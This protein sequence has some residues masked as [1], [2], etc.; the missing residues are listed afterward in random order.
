MYGYAV[1]KHVALQQDMIR[2]WQKEGDEVVA[3]AWILPEYGAN[4]CRFKVDETDYLY[5]A[6]Q[7]VLDFRHY[8]TPV[9]YPFPGVITDAKFT[10]DDQLYRFPPN[11]G[12]LYRHGFVMDEKF[13]YSEPIILDNGVMCRT[14]IEI[15]PHHPLYALLPISNRLDLDFTL[16]DRQL[17]ID[18]KVTNTDPEKRFPFGFGVHP[19]FNIIGT[20]D[21]TMIQVPAKA[22]VDRDEEKLVPIQEAP[23]DFRTLTPIDDLVIDDVWKGMTPEQPQ[24]I[25]YRAIGK[26]VTI[27]ASEI[28]EVAV[29]YR[30]EKADF[31]CMESW[32]TSHD[33]HNLYAKGK[34]DIANL[35]I[36]NP[37]ESVTGSLTYQITDLK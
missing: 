1:E 14:S 2:L 27:Y 34:Q 33:P 12:D 36:L 4:L 13:N 9:L 32:T 11:R 30:M 16:E 37:G 23:R 20:K 29:T 5:P 18:V 15:H 28:F 10:F 26:K 7:K 22:W 6:P 17:R 3:E 35:S 21:N 8:G 31:F 24:T 19:Y 25:E